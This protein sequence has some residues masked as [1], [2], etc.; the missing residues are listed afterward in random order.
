MRTVVEAPKLYIKYN[1]ADYSDWLN[2]QF[3]VGK[4]YVAP[5]NTGRWF[6]GCERGDVFGFN[7]M[8]LDNMLPFP[9]FE[10][11]TGS[12]PKQF[13]TKGGFTWLNH[14]A[15]IFYSNMLY[16]DWNTGLAAEDSVV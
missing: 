2:E 8:S 12:Y 13:P 1:C 5:D 16:T 10:K 15:I 7:R 9:I 4:W 6:D 14:K 11:L 3:G